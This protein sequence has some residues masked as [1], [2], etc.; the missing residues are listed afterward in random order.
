[1]RSDLKDIVCKK[2]REVRE[3]RMFLKMT[4]QERIENITL[5]LK[6][7]ENASSLFKSL[8]LISDKPRYLSKVNEQRLFKFANL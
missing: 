7:L 5:N 3:V 6:E 8:D 2:V 1:M 4:K